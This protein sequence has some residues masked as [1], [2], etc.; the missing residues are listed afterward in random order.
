M[1]EEPLKIDRKDGT[2]IV[3]L[4]MGRI[5]VE[6]DLSKF[7]VRQGIADSGST[8]GIALVPKRVADKQREE[9]KY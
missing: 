3:Q 7:E 5:R 9:A 2:I 1:F 4:H 8:I 6:C